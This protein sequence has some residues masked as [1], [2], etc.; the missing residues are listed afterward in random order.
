VTVSDLQVA[1][2]TTSVEGGNRLDWSSVTEANVDLTAD[3]QFKVGGAMTL[4]VADVLLVATQFEIN[5]QS[6]S[7]IDDPDTEQADTTLSGDLLTIGLTEAHV[8]AGTGATLDVSAGTLTVPSDAIGFEVSGASLDLAML[9]TT[10]DRNYTGLEA[11]FGTITVHG[12][13]AL[14]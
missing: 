3:D 10:D 2:T 9:Q 11:T 7:G 13:D 8:F 14:V 12:L 6:V 5:K 1:Y 4:D